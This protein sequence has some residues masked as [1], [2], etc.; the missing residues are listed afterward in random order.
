MSDYVVN[1]EL[2][3]D[4][5]KGASRRLRHAGKVPAVLYGGDKDPVSLTL[6][7]NEVIKHLE[8][9]G[10]YSHILTVKFGKGEEQAILKDLQRH[11]AKAA[12]LH[13][14][15]QRVSANQAIKVHVP[16]HFVGE[17]KAPGVKEGG[18]V[19]HNVTE[20]EV[21]C[22][23]KD[24]PEFLEVDLSELA[25]NGIVHMS[26]IKLPA[27]VELVELA[28]GAAHDQPIAS[29]HMP[30]GAKEEGAAAGEEA[31]EGGEEGGE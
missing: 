14:D 27:G 24:L 29:I 18:L 22:L 6:N 23:P 3:E 30:R 16:L 28:H 26:D 4:V 13:M 12:I 21:S 15:L 20:V 17:D 1:A 2:R 9:E 31:A 19:T 10:F 7:H 5:G 25:L 8:D 11:P